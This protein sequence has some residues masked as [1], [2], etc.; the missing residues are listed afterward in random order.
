M[1]VIDISP[2]IIEIPKWIMIKIKSLNWSL[3]RFQESLYDWD[4]VPCL[5]EMEVRVSVC[6]QVQFWN[7]RKQLIKYKVILKLNLIAGSPK[8]QLFVQLVLGLRWRCWLVTVIMTGKP[9]GFQPISLALKFIRL[10]LSVVNIV[11]FRGHF[12]LNHLTFIRTIYRWIPFAIVGVRKWS[13][14]GVIT[15]AVICILDTSFKSSQEFAHFGTVQ[16]A[17]ADTQLFLITPRNC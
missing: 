11:I 5:S 4:H 17:S 7:K 1:K 3:T 12:F 2:R 8:F 10:L 13:V 16:S 6:F 9:I 14:L 15:I